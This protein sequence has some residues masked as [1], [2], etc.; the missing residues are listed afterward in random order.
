[1]AADEKGRPFIAT[2]FREGNEAV[3]QYHIVYL[4]GKGWKTV[5]LSFR[6]TPFSLSGGGTKRI[7]I[8]RP[9]LL[10]KGSGKRASAL[11]LF[12]DEARGSRPSAVVIPKIGKKDWRLVDLLNEG[13][14]S[15]EP[16]FDTELW[17]KRRE[18]HLFI[19]KVEQVDGEGKADLL[20]QQVRVLQWKQSF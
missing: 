12:R 13:L 6:N 18:L 7:P 5:A 9:Q 10:V 17:E 1:M 4:G 20:P 19:Q 2:Y 8:S 14:G 15:W 11:L 16:S 3:P